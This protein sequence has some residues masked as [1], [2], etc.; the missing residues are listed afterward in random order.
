MLASCAAVAVLAGPAWGQEP[1]HAPQKETAP[2]A[3]D[4]INPDRP[5]IADGS[6]VIGPRRFQVELGWQQEE[7][8]DGGV[9]QRLQ[10]TPLLLRFGLTDRW[11]ARVE[12]NGYVRS[13]TVG[14]KGGAATTDG[15]AP[16]SL[17]AKLNFQP[18]DDKRPY[19]PSLGVIGR[20]FVPSGSSDFGSHRFT[21]DLRLAMDQN[22]TNRDNAGNW[23]WNPNLGLGWYEDDSGKTFLTGLVAATLNYVDRTKRWNPFVD[24]GLLAPEARRGRTQV[25]VDTGVGW[26][27]ARDTQLDASFGTG[28][29]GAAPPHPFWSV[30]VSQRF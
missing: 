20:V 14:G 5:G 16:V 30:G 19:K 21:A 25:V 1:A 9:G 4:L 24:F 29:L 8:N 6:A 23:S 15:Y 17:G 18:A 11:E 27:V 22:L 3:D 10:F 2:A 13:R 26:I 7:H 12:T 28:V